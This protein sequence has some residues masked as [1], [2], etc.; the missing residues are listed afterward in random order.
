V[1]DHG[2][3]EIEGDELELEVDDN[4]FAP[5]FVRGT[6]G[7]EVT[8]QLVNEGDASHTFTIDSLSVDEE[9]EGGA[10]SSVTLTLPDE[11]AVEFY[12]R[13]HEG[14]GMRGAFY[15]NEGDTVGAG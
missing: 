14:T 9:L 2:A 10:E 15:F 1:S 3:G 6:S 7:Q 11:G 12:C 8:V 5:T 4:Y 13:F